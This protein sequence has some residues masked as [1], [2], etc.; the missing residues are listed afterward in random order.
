MEWLKNELKAAKAAGA[1][2]IM[3]F[4]HHPF[5]L[6]RDNEDEDVR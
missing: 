4:C 6:V 3:I 2:H 1:A 5:F